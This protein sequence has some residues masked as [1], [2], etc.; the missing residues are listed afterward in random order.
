MFTDLRRRFARVTQVLDVGEEVPG[1]PR[2]DGRYS[3]IIQII[4]QVSG[5]RIQPQQFRM[6]R[7]WN[8]FGQS[9][10]AG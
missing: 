10:Y 9:T 5:D 3:T 8:D 1:K 4:D 2:R 7:Y 6:H